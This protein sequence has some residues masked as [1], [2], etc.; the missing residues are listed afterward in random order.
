[1]KL[2]ALSILCCVAISAIALLAQSGSTAGDPITGTWTGQ[3][4]GVTFELKFDGKETV[5][6][7]VTPQ[8]GEI[9][10]GSFDAKTSVLHLE[11]DAIPPDGS[12]QCRFVIEGKL[13]NG[14][15]AGTAVC[16]TIKVADFKMTRQ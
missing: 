8:P 5:T 4:Q 16:G 12:G 13:E 14:T 2:K 15:V 9:K 7:K 3:P 1:M 10:K 6:G 11:G